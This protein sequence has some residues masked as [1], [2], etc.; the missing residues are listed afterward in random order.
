MPLST[1]WLM[2]A[3]PFCWLWQIA[4]GQTCDLL[5]ADLSAQ[6]DALVREEMLKQHVVGLTL[7]IIRNGEVVYMKGYG[8][9]D[10]EYSIPAEVSTIYR[11]ASLSKVITSVAAL[12]AWE[13]GL[14]NLQADVREYVPEYPAKP[15]GIIT[16]EQLLACE[17]GIQQYNQVSDFNTDALVQYILDHPQDYDP[18]AAIDI[19]KDQ[20]LLARPG[21]QFNYST[22]SFNLLAAVIE[23]AVGMPYETYVDSLLIQPMQLPYLQP[24]FRALRPYP[25]Q[26][27]WYRV[28][29]DSAIADKIYGY[30]YEDVSWKLG[31]GGYT[32]TIVDLSGF[33]RA[34]LNG[35]LLKKNTRN[36]MFTNR[37]VNGKN[38]WY[39]M[40]VFLGSRH[41]EPI[42]SQ[43][44]HQAGARSIMYLAPESRDG[45]LILSNTYGTDLKSLAEGLWD[46]T[47]KS[48][49]DT[50][51]LDPFSD[52]L[53]QP[54]WKGE[55]EVAGTGV[56]LHWD[57]VEQANH[58]EVQWNTRN[59]FGEVTMTDPTNWT[60]QL[61]MERGLKQITSIP[62]IYLYDLPANTTVFLRVRALNDYLHEGVEG[63]WSKV[64]KFRS[65]STS[66][67][68][69]VP[70]TMVFD[71]LNSI[72]QGDAL[73]EASPG[74]EWKLVRSEDGLRW[75]SGRWSLAPSG[76]GLTLDVF[77]GNG[78]ASGF[79]ELT[80]DLTG[81][82]ESTLRF[83]LDY[84]LHG[85]GDELPEVACWVRGDADDTWIILPEKLNGNGQPG[86]QHTEFELMEILQ[87]YGQQPGEFFQF[88][89]GFYA[90]SDAHSYLPQ[91][92]ITLLS[93]V[94]E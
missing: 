90:G 61:E 67:A 59:E 40:G 72:G 57:P 19:F 1:K 45:I 33:A 78:H 93:C 74:V 7:G 32:G 88:R 75:R 71:K 9:A 30:D 23:R 13:N 52:Q 65:G 79:L 25:N 14:L 26:S 70:Y 68:A 73:L 11:F 55:P 6:T 64:L 43:F 56:T 2:L 69:P 60:R 29:G 89:L 51:C 44:G 94:V 80:M 46:I 17:G 42:V 39:G 54:V 84:L 49:R 76:G 63:P 83:S 85:T 92:A 35:S 86:E 18:V 15:E 91:P 50:L 37:K 47:R 58:Y 20:A 62:S 77:P 28:E 41:G 36:M 8:F 34:L 24:E 31:G 22:F 82:S 38:S 10:R 87:N 21:T 53:T 12:H 27:S 4:S 81:Y 16:V 3:Q 5:G 48:T 66:Q